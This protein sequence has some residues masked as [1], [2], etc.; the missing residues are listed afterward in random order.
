MML[1]RTQFLG[2]LIQMLSE[3]IGE[4]M[5][6]FTT[7]G[8]VIF[9]FLLIGRFLSEELQS[10]IA[11][12]WAVFLDLFDAFNGKPHFENFTQPAGQMYIAT[13]L[14]IFKILLVSLLAAM[15]INKYKIVW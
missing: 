2:E 3:M 12:Y 7:F 5:R 9:L 10:N 14:F 1:K 4:L 6:F 13:F 15:F 11:S 8:L